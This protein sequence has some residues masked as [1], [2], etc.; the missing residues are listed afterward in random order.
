MTVYALVTRLRCPMRLSDS[1]TPSLSTA[2]LKWHASCLLL[3]YGGDPDIM[4]LITKAADAQLARFLAQNGFLSEQ[5][6]QAAL[7]AAAKGTKATLIEHLSST[8]LINE[9]A[10]ARVL[11]DRLRI[12]YVNLAAYPLDN[13]SAALIKEEL[14]SRYQI[15]PLRLQDDC[16]I[17]AMANPLDRD[18]MKAVEF[19]TGR[20]VRPEVSTASAVRDAIDHAYHLEDAL[21][22]YLEGVPNEGEGPITELHEESTD[23]RALVRG[24]Q[25]PPVVKLLN[26]ILV[27]GIRAG[28]SDIHIETSVSEV[29]VRYRID[30]VLQEAFR[31]PK[32]VQDPLTARCKV[33]ASLDIT[34]RR[35]PQDGRIRIRYQDSMIDLRVSS[36]PTQFGEKITMRILD[37]NAGPAN[38]DVLKLAPRDQQ[39][40]RG[41]IQRPQGMV[42]VTGPTG[43]GK[44]TTLYGMIAELVSPTRNIVTIEN[45]IEYQ[46]R[47]VNQVEINERQGLTFAGTLRSILRQ[48]P[49]V[50][51]VGEI[52]DAE[53]ASIAIRA[54]QTG[55]LVLSTLHTNDC[56]STVSRLLDL[57]IDPFLIASSVHV[58]VA[59]RLT[60]RICPQCSEPYEPDPA[61]V[62]AAHI[63]PE[64]QVF[65]QGRG[66]S[67]CRKTGYVGREAVFEVMPMTSGL[68]KL[69][70]ARAPESA[71]RVQARSDGMVPLAER[72]VE[73]ILDRTTTI[74]EVLRVV[75]VMEQTARCPACTHIVEESFAVCPACAAP[76]QTTCEG[77]G[78]RLQKGWQ[79]CPY[80]GGAPTKSPAVA[81]SPPTEA[82]AE[83]AA[84]APEPDPA[85]RYHALV[86]DDERDFRY[87]M[88]VFLQHSG[89]PL[90]VETASNG[91]EAIEKVGLNPPD[92]VLLD[93][94]MPEMDGFEVCRQ[95][96]ANVRTAFIPILMLTALDD[97]ENRTRGFLAGTDDYIGKPFDR[98]ELLARVGRVLHRTYGVCFD[99]IGEKSNGHQAIAAEATATPATSH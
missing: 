53:T 25:L 21:N 29:R 30:G 5:A 86:V 82:A 35:V 98:G 13:S 31:L 46:L 36:L 50:I 73:K 57:G 60:R 54:A 33:L 65:Y 51:L 70:E 3:R 80:C 75:D 27:D 1:T 23:L 11:A 72:A 99:G 14:V 38:L 43:S 74:E 18:G 78:R 20:R 4:S 69:I 17:V 79:T 93:V 32:W 52:R 61:M 16:L 76:L 37:P 34:E 63:D 94:M 62:R 44:T 10:V 41:A 40:L 85:R 68:G 56:V 66:C 24:T 8:G 96:R 91:R 15:V 9:E 92:I 48:D 12:P 95:L 39:I 67:S 77:C 90:D 97:S 59:Q 22:A 84:Q 83:P 2:N 45:P 7:I 89:M 71:C 47:G 42:L 49:D 64:G 55:H 58:I 6:A 28:A 26:L 87:L 19:A 88:T 81:A